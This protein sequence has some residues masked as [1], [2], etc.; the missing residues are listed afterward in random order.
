M[1]KPAWVLS[2]GIHLSLGLL[3]VTRS[4]CWP[5]AMQIMPDQLRLRLPAWLTSCRG[6]SW[7]VSNAASRLLLPRKHHI[8]RSGASERLAFPLPLTLAGVVAKQGV[9]NTS[10]QMSAHSHRSSVLKNNLELTYSCCVIDWF[11]CLPALLAALIGSPPRSP[12]LSWC[13]GSFGRLLFLSAS[14]E[15]IRI[16]PYL[17]V[18]ACTLTAAPLELWRVL[19]AESRLKMLWG[20]HM[21]GIKSAIAFIFLA[22]TIKMSPPHK[23]VSNASSASLTQNEGATE[24]AGSSSPEVTRVLQW[25]TLTGPEILDMWPSYSPKLGI[26]PCNHFIYDLI[27]GLL[28]HCSELA[29]IGFLENKPEC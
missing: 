5:T 13:W 4:F 15:K 10:A 12:L 8:E 19:L 20:L 28:S 21:V 2:V 9:W 24:N 17:L 14:Q 11:S 1:E 7:T 25:L 22:L 16:W 18:P 26:H 23:C 3:C 29:E 6:T 27:S